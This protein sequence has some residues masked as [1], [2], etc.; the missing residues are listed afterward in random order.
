MAN[1]S[2]AVVG[3][4]TTD[5]VRF[6]ESNIVVCFE[7]GPGAGGMG[8]HT[9]GGSAPVLVETRTNF[10]LE[11]LDP[12]YYVASKLGQALPVYRVTQVPAASGESFNAYICSYGQHMTFGVTLGKAA[13]LMV[14]AQMDGCSLGVGS[15]ASDGSRLVYHSNAGGDAA[16]QAAALAAALPGGQKKWEKTDY[17][18]D[19]LIGYWG[20]NQYLKSTAIGVLKKDTWTFWAQVY[21]WVKAGTHSETVTLGADQGAFAGLTKTVTKEVTKI[22]LR[23]VRKIA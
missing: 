7:G 20:F 8:S 17:Q 22:Y 1:A 3:Q 5:P 2:K 19:K 13:N 23:D 15:A 6:M 18:T 10:V 14:T 9:G 16:K 4:F 21:E 12:P 11:I